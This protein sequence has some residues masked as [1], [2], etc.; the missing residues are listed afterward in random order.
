VT[1]FNNGSVLLVKTRRFW[2]DIGDVN[3]TS[4]HLLKMEQT[5][6]DGTLTEMVL[7][8]RVRD[9]QVA[10]GYDVDPR[11]GKVEIDG[12]TSDE[13]LFNASGD[14]LGS[15]GLSGGLKEDLRRIAIGVAVST[16]TKAKGGNSVQLLD[17]DVLTHPDQFF[18]GAVVYLTFRNSFIFK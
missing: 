15:G 12:T 8:D 17:G 10:L 16:P 14:A 13:W 18:R 6:S 5:V 1:R 2:L 4:T 9:F 11:N 3:D 7:A